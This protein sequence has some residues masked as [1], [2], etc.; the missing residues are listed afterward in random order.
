M[1]QQILDAIR[2]GN[3]AF[4][5]ALFVQMGLTN[6]ARLL[7]EAWAAG[8]SGEPLA[9]FAIGLMD[10]ASRRAARA[11]VPDEIAGQAVP[12]PGSSMPVAP[13]PQAPIALSLIGD[14][15]GAVAPIVGGALGSV[16]PGIGTAAGA[17]LGGVLSGGLGN[18]SGPGST[19]GTGGFSGLPVMPGGLLTPGIGPTLGQVGGALQNFPG[20]L[21]N[22]GFG[23]GLNGS[24]GPLPAQPLPQLTMGP[25]FATSATKP[26]QASR[27][28][29]PMGFV[30]V[31]VKP[32][33]PFFSSAMQIG[34][35]VQRDGAVKIAM[36]KEVARKMGYWKP[37]VRPLLTSS[38]RKTIR[39]AQTLKRKVARVAKMAGVDCKL[40]RRR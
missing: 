11:V 12:L 33:D 29:A 10:V 35:V 16:I 9:Q 34:G 13:L 20:I 7:Q 32:N 17:A 14:I 21:N 3:A 22:L 8:K 1:M 36:R 2:A 40:P 25:G 24:G 18:L 39:R 19:V 30:I 37:K 6:E 28:Q 26:T 38:E 27:L 15:L 5:S 31:T 4:A 23:P